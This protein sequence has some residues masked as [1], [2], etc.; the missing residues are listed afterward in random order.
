MRR[1]DAIQ[2][3]VIILASQAK[4]NPVSAG[5]ICGQKQGAGTP[6]RGQTRSLGA[7]GAVGRGNKFCDISNAMQFTSRV[8]IFDTLLRSPKAPR[9]DRIIP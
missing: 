7:L 6:V 1:P 4:Q 2:S 5:N 3:Q 9:L 8:H